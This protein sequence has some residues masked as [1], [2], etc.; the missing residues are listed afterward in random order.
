[1]NVEQAPGTKVSE[2]ASDESMLREIQYVDKTPS[3]EELNKLVKKI[4]V[5]I[6]SLWRD[7]EWAPDKDIFDKL[8]MKQFEWAPDKDMFD[9]LLMK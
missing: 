9:K 4:Y 1:M 8:L 6:S 5:W 7:F 3:K 2:E